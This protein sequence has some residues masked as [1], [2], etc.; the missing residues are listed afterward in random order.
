MVLAVVLLGRS[1]PR[2]SRL[3]GYRT[4]DRDEP[5]APDEERGSAERENDDTHWNWPSALAGRSIPRL[6]SVVTAHSNARR[7]ELGENRLDGTLGEREHE[8]KRPQPLD[9]TLRVQARLGARLGPW[10]RP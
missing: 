5:T 6:P 10:R 1:W 9:G 4:R 7:S 3:G 2:S 8:W